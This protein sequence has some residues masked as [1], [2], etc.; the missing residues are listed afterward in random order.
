M[1]KAYGL[2]PNMAVSTVQ[3][4]VKVVYFLVVSARFH[5]RVCPSVCTFVRSLV[6]PLVKSAIFKRA[7]TKMTNDLPLSCYGACFVNLYVFYLVDSQAVLCSR[8]LL[9]MAL[10]RG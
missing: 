8:F 7:V 5:Q 3:A 2:I 4:G 10:G 6:R 1:E 9:L